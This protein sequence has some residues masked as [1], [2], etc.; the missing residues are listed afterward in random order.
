MEQNSETVSIGKQIEDNSYKNKNE[1]YKEIL[2]EGSKIDRYDPKTYTLHEVK[3]SNKMEDSH[4]AQ[5][6]Y[7]IYLLQKNNIKIKKAIIDYPKLKK[8][9]I[10]EVE[11]VD[12]K[13]IKSWLF[14][15]E[16]ICN[17][18]VCPDLLNEPICK[19]CSY[20]D[21]CYSGEKDEELLLV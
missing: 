3:K 21:F 8:N 14:E 12:D 4:I 15:I 2:I 18:K 11:S 16:G 10:I 1:K 6:K 7:Y 17:L 9:K 20:F 13:E 19:K 5:L